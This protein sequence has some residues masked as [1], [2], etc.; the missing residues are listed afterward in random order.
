M[1]L[2]L[3]PILILEPFKGEVEIQPQVVI[4]GHHHVGKMEINHILIMEPLKG[5]VAIQ[6]Q[7]VD[8]GYRHAG[9]ME[10]KLGP[11]LMLDPLKVKLRYNL[12]L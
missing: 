5:E 7:V 6:P 1:E 11:I 3:G 9:E 2:K 8:R 4:H 10:L 12:R